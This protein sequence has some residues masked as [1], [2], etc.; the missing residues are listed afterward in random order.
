MKQN[1][2][3][4]SYD[5]S[6][7]GKRHRLNI[8]L[9]LLF[10]LA[11]IAFVFMLTTTKSLPTNWYYLIGTILALTFLILLLITYTKI[12]GFWTFLYRFFNL[13]LT[14]CL[15][16]GSV[17]VYEVNTNIQNI[18]DSDG[19]AYEQISIVTS[20][21][22]S[23]ETV[24]DLYEKRVGY[25][26]GSDD[27]NGSY[28]KYEL[29][30]E[31]T[32][33]RFVPELSYNQL[34]T[35]L[36]DQELDAVIISDKQ[37]QILTAADDSIY[38]HIR[39]IKSYQKKKDSY[40]STS[41]KDI[42][43]ETFTIYLSGI[44]EAVDP[45]Q[46]LRSDVNMLLIVNPLANHVEMISFPRDA[47]IPNTG[48]YGYNDKLTHTG[49]YGVDATIDS[50]SA[51]LGIEIDFFVKVSFTSVIE[52]V[53]ALGGIDVDVMVEFCES[54]EYR[55]TDQSDL[56][57]LEAGV[58]TLNGSQ[59][60]AFAR[61]RKSYGD[62]GRNQ[63][64]Q[65]VLAAMITKL[66]SPAGVTRINTLLSVAPTFVVTNIPTNQV[67]D[68][69]S[70]QLDNIKP[71]TFGSYIVDGTFGE[72]VTASIAGLPLSVYYLSYH[73]LQYVY[74][75]Y[76]AMKESMSMDDFAFDLNNL[77]QANH[78]LPVLEGMVYAEARGFIPPDYYE[79]LTIDSPQSEE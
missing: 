78:I 31:V 66:L 1:Y 60:L 69:I 19:R 45:N 50:M 8:F 44:D 28:A 15:I 65:R 51:V 9:S 47:Y 11:S 12:R 46:D 23:V 62:I 72:E 35:T 7:F 40:T 67:M 49:I 70:Y 18:L 57:C 30:K 6:I 74:D 26:N 53:N 21:D 24:E 58:Q 14:A 39:V 27:V 76:Y 61:H 68:F 75:M 38:E 73:S 2:E 10:G 37:L 52:I 13:S 5:R 16:F 25:Q 20:V 55:S 64:Q 63:A 3:H 54:N 41:T 17:F 29:S 34:L 59:A 32:N 33:I 43:N 48:A 77:K 56:I 22:S 36:I 4:Q 79:D 42:R 71:W